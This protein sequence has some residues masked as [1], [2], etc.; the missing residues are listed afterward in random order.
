MKLSLK[1]EALWGFL[2]FFAAA[3][4]LYS[5]TLQYGFVWDDFIEVAGNDVFHHWQN[6][7]KFFTVPYW[8]L[9]TGGF[10]PY[11]RPM[12]PVMVLLVST[13]FGK[14]PFGYHLLNILLYSATCGIYFLFLRKLSLSRWV[15]WAAAALFLF[16]PVHVETVAWGSARPV[17]LSGLCFIMCLFSTNLA[18][19]LFFYAVGLLT[20]HS[21]LTLLPVLFMVDF[22]IRKKLDFKKYAAIVLLTLIFLGYTFFIFHRTGE[23]DLRPYYSPTGANLI[24]SGAPLELFLAPINTASRYAEALLFPLN[25][26]PDAYFGAGSLSLSALACLIIAALLTIVMNLRL[27]GDQKI[28]FFSLCW[29]FFPLIT[30]MN[31]LPQGGLFSD[32]YLFISSMGFAL[33]AALALDSLRVSDTFRP[34][35]VRHLLLGGLILFYGFKVIS[36]SETFRNDLRYWL[37]ASILSPQKARTHDKLGIALEA[38]GHLKEAAEE[39]KTTLE[40]DPVNFIMTYKRLADTLKKLGLPEEAATYESQFQEAVK[41]AREKQQTLVISN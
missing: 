35:S 13:F 28:L 33:W 38:S 14:N 3:F 31:F 39:Y 22:L 18:V 32:R 37:E 10:A 24:Y 5:P 21:I 25:L 7:P 30:V 12:I 17:L 1:N 41:K 8:S 27:F 11:H 16:H 20:Y 15:V 26:T 6:L 9:L 40:L 19:T 4:L 29:I 23:I 34:K 36:Y 2:A